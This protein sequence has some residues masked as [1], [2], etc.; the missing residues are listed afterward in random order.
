MT[1]NKA[2]NV[3]EM[4]SD[5]SNIVQYTTHTQQIFSRPY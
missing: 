4:A 3:I 5:R 1:L 2:S